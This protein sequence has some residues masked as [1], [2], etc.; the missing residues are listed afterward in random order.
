M[1]TMNVSRQTVYRES[2][3]TGEKRNLEGTRTGNA[4]PGTL[5]VGAVALILPF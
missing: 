5:L 4:E 3:K 1:Q 2:S